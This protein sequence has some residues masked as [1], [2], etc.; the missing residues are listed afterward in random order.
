[1][2]I[3]FLLPVVFL[4]LVLRPVLAAETHE[5]LLGPH[6]RYEIS[7]TRDWRFE[8]LREL[9]G[10]FSDVRIKPK[11][12]DDF[13]LTLYF[14]ADPPELARLDTPDKIASSVAAGA[15]KYLPQIVEKK[16]TLQKVSPRGSYGSLTVL[17]AAGLQGAPGEFRYQT[18][19]MVRLSSDAALG[20]SLLSNEV[21]GIGYRQLLNHVYSF[22][23]LTPN[24]TA[25]PAAAPT[26]APVPTSVPTPAPAPLPRATPVPER[27]PA[28][29]R[30]PDA[31]PLPS[32]TPAPSSASS[33]PPAPRPQKPAQR[34]PRQDM[35]DCLNLPTDAE[36]MRCVSGRK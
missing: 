29:V 13:S 11:R 22:V 1:M 12:G 17:T 14:L 27:P 30:V 20:F 21:N 28:A 18:R 36:I 19:G 31:A 16:I 10:Q 5:V 9:A 3:A 26:P 24:S 34:G 2:R 33:S 4:S 32:A 7:E 8:V 15:E 6:D 25:K 23:R 35:R